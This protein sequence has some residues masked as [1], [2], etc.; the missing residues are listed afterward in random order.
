MKFTLK[1]YQEEAV[2]K[3]LENLKKASRRWQQEGERNAFSLSAA[4]GAGKTVMAAAVF[5][6]LFHGDDTYDFIADPT[7]TVI[8]FSDDPSLNEQT[9]HRLLEASDR[10]ERTDLVVV[11]NTF[12]RDK[13]EAGKIYFLNTQKLSKRSLLVR[14]HEL[15]EDDP[16]FDLLP[17]AKPDLRSQTIWDTIQNTIDDSSLTLYLVLDEAHRGMGNLSSSASKDRTTI[18]KKLINGVSST[19]AI[20]IVVGISATVERFD[21][22]IKVSEKRSRLENVVVDP[23]KVQASGLLKDTIILDVKEKVGKFDT[24]LIR[25]AIHKLKDVSEAWEQYAKIQ[26]EEKRVKPLMVIQVPNTPDHK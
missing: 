10:I 20:P 15:N 24:V 25:R 19:S 4:T 1:D 2:D 7:A 18:V 6:A 9:K 22:A 21:A 5:E 17:R 3:V 23:A 13:F 8:W 11:E 12:N 26:T 16:Q 14:G